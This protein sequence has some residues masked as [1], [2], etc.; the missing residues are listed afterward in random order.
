MRSRSLLINSTKAWDCKCGRRW[1]LYYTDAG[2]LIVS[3]RPEGRRQTGLCH[4]G[5]SLGTE[6]VA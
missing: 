2:E 6:V 3:N 4:C 1:A 5:K